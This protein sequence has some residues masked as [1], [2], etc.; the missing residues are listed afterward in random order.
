MGDKAK[1]FIEI[2]VEDFQLV[3][4]VNKIWVDHEME[5]GEFYPDFFPSGNFK[6]GKGNYRVLCKSSSKGKIRGN[7]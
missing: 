1:D 4:E 3:S 6:V 2:T 7:C 5:Q